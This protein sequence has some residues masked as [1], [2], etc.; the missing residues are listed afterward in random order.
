MSTKSWYRWHVQCATDSAF[1]TTI[2][3][4]SDEPTVCPNNAAHSVVVGSGVIDKKLTT[5]LPAIDDDGE[6]RVLVSIGMF[7][8]YMNP[9]FSGYGDDFDAGTRAN[10]QRLIMQHADGADEVNITELRFVDL[11][12]L[13]GGNIR[14]FDANIDDYISFD[15]IAPASPVVL[16]VSQTGN[17]NAVPIASIGCS[18]IVPAGGDGWHDVDTAAAVNANLDGSGPILVTAVVPV[19]SYD[20]NDQ[21]SGY[22]DWDRKTGAVTPNYTATGKYNLFDGEIPLSVYINKICVYGGASGEFSQKIRV[23]HRSGPIL[24]HWKC[25]IHT[26]RASSHDAS[27]P[28]VRYTVFI[29]GARAS[30]I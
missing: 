27:D 22:W 9:Y 15:C 20:D 18:I 28:P 30:S 21:P 24:P 13:V 23:T 6:K 1:Y 17:A 26:T 12:Q 16:N 25:R 5:T 19:P 2:T 3:E 8:D 10:G 11:V 7:P 14:A 4:S 29:T